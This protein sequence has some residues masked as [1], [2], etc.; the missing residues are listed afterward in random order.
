MK[1]EKKIVLAAHCLLN[2][3]AK[4]MGI[5]GEKGG[6]PLIG[7]LLKAGYGVIQ[8]PCMEMA[9]YGSQRW[10]IVY[11]QNDFPEFREK[12][13]EA[14]KP[15]VRQVE[16]YARHG[17]EIAA[18]IGVDGSPTCGVNK[19]VTGNWGGEFNEENRYDERLKTLKEAKGAG[20]F[21]EELK[22]MLNECGIKTRFLAVNEADMSSTGDIIEQIQAGY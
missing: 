14:L 16:D 10:G 4:V 15:V 12:C 2:V 22:A 17:Y 11:E 13:R 3:N 20:V 6:S 18:V 9:V 21:I 7:E 5:A 1:R 19:T 8:L